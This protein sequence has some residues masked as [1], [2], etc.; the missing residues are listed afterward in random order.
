M[1]LKVYSKPNPLKVFDKV[2]KLKKLVKPIKV[3]SND[4]FIEKLLSKPKEI[5][6]I[7][8]SGFSIEDHNHINIKCELKCNLPISFS[9]QRSHGGANC[10]VLGQKLDGTDIDNSFGNTKSNLIEVLENLELP[11]KII[12]TEVEMTQEI[13]SSTSVF[14]YKLN[15]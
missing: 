1:D 6:D 3:E 4:K 10:W 14:N 7:I 2:S 13:G 8:G 5:L 15:L 9:A 12:F 11:S